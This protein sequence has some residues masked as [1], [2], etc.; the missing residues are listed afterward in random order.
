[1][2]IP[3]KTTILLD[4][5]SSD[6]AHSWFVPSLTGSFEALPGF[7]NKAWFR[8]DKPGVYYEGGSGLLSGPNYANMTTT[9][10]VVSPAEFKQWAADQLSAYNA[11]CTALA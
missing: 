2:V 4:I 3:A 7:V 8:A 6:V 5:T 1:M 9:V 10:R 11:A